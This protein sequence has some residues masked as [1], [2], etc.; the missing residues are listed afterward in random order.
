M[1]RW[2]TFAFSAG[3]PCDSDTIA[4]CISALHQRYRV[5]FA[6]RTG[7]GSDRVV[8]ADKRGTI[9]IPLALVRLAELSLCFMTMHGP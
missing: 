5:L 9:S 8:G 4:H 3:A 2:G 1:E 6:F 7:S